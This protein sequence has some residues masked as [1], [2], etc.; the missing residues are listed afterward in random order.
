ME[1]RPDRGGFTLIE[2]LIVVTLIAVIAAIAIP[3]M[4]ESRK[5]GNET[6][7]IASLREIVSSE[8]LFREGDKEK[9][10]NLD[11]GMLSELGA[12]GILEPVLAGGT[13]HGYLFEASYSFT[14]PTLIWFGVTR[15]FLPGNTGDRYFATS[16]AGVIYYTTAIE[17]A[18]DTSSCSMPGNVI[19]IGK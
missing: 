1:A 4:V 2:L 18:L 5:R 9:D 10:G 8:T 14:S 11:Y 16:Q 12:V 3:N 6:A 19:P 15:P 13:K 17:V 7:A